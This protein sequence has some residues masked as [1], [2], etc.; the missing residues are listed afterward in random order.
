[1]SNAGCTT[2]QHTQ[3][4]TTTHITWNHDRRIAVILCDFEDCVKSQR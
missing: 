3:N 2:I 1:M 4:R